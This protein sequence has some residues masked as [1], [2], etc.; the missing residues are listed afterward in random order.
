MAWKYMSLMNKHI[1]LSRIKNESI[2]SQYIFK[3]VFL[4]FLGKNLA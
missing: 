4:N 1:L 2:Y 3:I